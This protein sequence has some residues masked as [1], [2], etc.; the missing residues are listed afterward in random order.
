M[1]GNFSIDLSK[2]A[3]KTELNFDLIVKKVI[4][5]IFSDIVKSTPRDTGRAA[6]NWQI[7]GSLNS[8]QVSSFDKSGQVAITQGKAQVQGLLTRAQLIGYI[9][10]NVEY[11]GLLEDGHSK[12]APRGMVKVTLTRYQTYINNAV[13]SLP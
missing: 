6:S 11:I 4:F 3:K 9:Y 7:G 10:N 8:G 1:V 13:R 5:D 12:Q 2:F